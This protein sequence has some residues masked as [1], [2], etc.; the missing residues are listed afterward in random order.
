M[1]THGESIT[2]LGREQLLAGRWLGQLMR[3]AGLQIFFPLELEQGLR[4]QS[5]EG[6]RILAAT[7]GGREESF[8][9]RS[10]VA[11]VDG[12]VERGDC[13]PGP[14]A[15]GRVLVALRG[16]FLGRGD[17]LGGAA[18]EQHGQAKGG[19]QGEQRETQHVSERAEGDWGQRGRSRGHTLA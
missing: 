7:A 18:G 19:S 6:A 11:V 8:P 13:G 3:Q 16:V 12:K 17:L 4:G 15:V 2:R 5:S 9:I 10:L 14:E 1:S